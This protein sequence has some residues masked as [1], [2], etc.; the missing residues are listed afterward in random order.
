MKINSL[1][2]KYGY[3]IHTLL[4]KAF[5]GTLV[6]RASPS[7]HEVSLE[8]THTVPL[9]ISFFKNIGLLYQYN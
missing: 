7:L 1:N 8:I 9:S 2:K 4:D 6:N 5:K 3:L